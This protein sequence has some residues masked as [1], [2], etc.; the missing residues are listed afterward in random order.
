M[1]VFLLV[2]FFISHL[3]VA[4]VQV[5]PLYEELPCDTIQTTDLS[6]HSEILPAISN[7]QI[8]TKSKIG[9][10]SKGISSNYF[11]INGLLDIGFTPSNLQYR[12]GLGASIES[13]FANKWFFR[14][15][16]IEGLGKV[17]NSFLE[18]KAYVFSRAKNSSIQYTDIRGRISFS[19]NHI[20]NFQAG[21][22]NNFI[23]EGNRSLLLSDYSVA[24]PFAQIRA[25]FWRI[26]YLMLYQFYRE[27]VKKNWKSKYAGTHYLSINATKWLNLGFFETVV[28]QPKDTTL[29]RGFDAEYLN[30]IIFY[31]PQE[32]SMGSSD[33]IIMG[34]H[35]SAK[36]KKHTLYGQIVLDEFLLGELK[37][38]SK[39]WGNKYGAQLGI[40]GRVKTKMGQIFYRSEFNFARP[41]T[42]SHAHYSENYGNQGYALAHPYGG[43]FAELLVEAKWQRENWI[44][45]FFASYFLKGYDKKDGLSY[46]G[47]IYQSYN[48]R[49]HEYNNLIGQGNGNNGS[50]IIL[51][52][53]YRIDSA[54]NLQIFMENQLRINTYI[55]EPTYYLT[56]G[57]RSC[58]WNDYR[59]Y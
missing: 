55:H 15:A 34:F 39:W 13:Q 22:D 50:R 29:N 40:K 8:P 25:K 32:Y 48:N 46:G 28:F 7:T 26:E 4:Q 17:D 16:A 53:A 6:F 42:Y 27:E 19:P 2:V 51:S 3:S 37:A 58:L 41:Y 56:V 52:T 45:K 38:R 20:F 24:S 18:P 11:T 44:I 49:P 23:G 33:N 10:I 54:T 14:V 47:D 30:P 1:K 59:N 21:I 31:R 9:F 12:T 36:Y 43:S 35:F 57:I 5:K